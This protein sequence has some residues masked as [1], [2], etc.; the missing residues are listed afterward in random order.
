MECLPIRE[1][2]IFDKRADAYLIAHGLDLGATIVTNE[3]SSPNKT[4]PLKKKIP[5]ICRTMGVGCIRYPRFLWEMKQG[6]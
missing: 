1:L 5:D 6:K 3:V 4:A 2:E